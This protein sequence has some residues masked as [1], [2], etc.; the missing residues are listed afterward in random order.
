VNVHAGINVLLHV[1]EF[2]VPLCLLLGCDCRNA[3]NVPENVITAFYVHM[4]K[5]CNG[6]GGRHTTMEP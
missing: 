6:M 4:E 1:T 5:G 2:F 3:A